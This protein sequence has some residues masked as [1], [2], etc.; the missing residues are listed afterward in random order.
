MRSGQLHCNVVDGKHDAKWK[1][2]VPINSVQKAIFVCHSGVRHNGAWW[3]PGESTAYPQG[4][5]SSFV[6]AGFSKFSKVFYCR[7]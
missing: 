5:Y 6:D 7:V 1:H 4:S 3:L 2:G